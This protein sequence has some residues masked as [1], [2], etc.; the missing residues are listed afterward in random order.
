MKLQDAINSGLTC[1]VDFDRIKEALL[2]DLRDYVKVDKII[3][4]YE[5]Q[6]SE[7]GELLINTETRDNKE[8]IINLNGSIIEEN[9]KFM[10][11]VFCHEL[12]HFIS[13]ST[14]KIPKTVTEAMA[15]EEYADNYG[16]KLW[17][18]HFKS[19]EYYKTSED[20]ERN[21]MRRELY[22]KHY[23]GE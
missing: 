3:M 7:Y 10:L 13:L 11:N 15:E 8:L 16:L 19:E 4:E 21:V 6:Y 1:K 18:K 22:R 12:G 2:T 23:T 20:E 5:T 17:S 9:P 14:G